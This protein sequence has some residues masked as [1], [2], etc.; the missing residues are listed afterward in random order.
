MRSLVSPFNSLCLLLFH[1]YLL[2]SASPI[3]LSKIMGART[4]HPTP[5]SNHLRASPFSFKIFTCPSTQ[6]PYQNLIR[7]SMHP[8][9]SRH[10]SFILMGGLSIFSFVACPSTNSLLIH[11]GMTLPGYLHCRWGQIRQHV[12]TPLTS[13]TGLQIAHALDLLQIDGMH[14]PHADTAESSPTWTGEN[15]NGCE[16]ICDGILSCS[17]ISNSHIENIIEPIISRSIPKSNHK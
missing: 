11:L 9:S 10:T 12:H 3:N 13:L 6:Q 14:S 15:N 5:Q 16:G 4:T 2:S 7:H 8:S 17:C 1:C